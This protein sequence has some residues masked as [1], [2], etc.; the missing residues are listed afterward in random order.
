MANLDDSERQKF[1]LSGGNVCLFTSTET[2]GGSVEAPRD[3]L[4]SKKFRADSAIRMIIV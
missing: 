3:D 2:A 1:L 4:E